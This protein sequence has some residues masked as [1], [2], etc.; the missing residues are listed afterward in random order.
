[1]ANKIT[2]T[3]QLIKE[4]DTITKSDI[5]TYKR[6]YED[7]GEIDQYSATIDGKTYY[8]VTSRYVPGKKLSLWTYISQLWNKEAEVAV[9][10]SGPCYEICL[11]DNDSWKL[12]ATRRVEA[13]LMKVKD[14][15]ER[16]AIRLN[17]LKG[18]VKVAEDAKK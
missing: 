1:M 9:K 11:W 13:K 4:L 3:E 10:T 6:M 2:V 12:A 15:D 7:F 18:L 14:P 17:I 16:I 5:M 8:N